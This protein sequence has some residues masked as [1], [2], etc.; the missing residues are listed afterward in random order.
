MLEKVVLCIV[1][2]LMIGI[3]DNGWDRVSS[4]KEVMIAGRNPSDFTVKDTYAALP[5][6]WTSS[7][8]KSQVK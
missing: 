3:P 7:P 6:N 5:P 2:R 8:T 1:G 4:A